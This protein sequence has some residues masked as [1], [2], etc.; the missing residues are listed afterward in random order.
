MSRSSS[1]PVELGLIAFSTPF[2]DSA[3]AYLESPRRAVLQDRVVREHRPA[4]HSP[5]GGHRQA[6]DRFDRHGDGGGAGRNRARRA[7]GG[8]PRSGPAQVHQLLPGIARTDEPADDPAPAN[9]VR[10]RSR[11]VR[12]HQRH[13][14]GGRQR[15]A[16]RD[17]RREAPDAAPCR[18]GSGQRLLPGA[19]GAGRSWW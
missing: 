5:G 2:D 9:A 10:L 13:R 19:G 14:G 15:R 6:D 3:V 12:P 16:G 4:A 11:V 7:R 1:G 8:L 18:W 17:R